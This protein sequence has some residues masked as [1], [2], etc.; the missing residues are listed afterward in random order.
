MRERSNYKDAEMYLAG[1]DDTTTAAAHYLALQHLARVLSAGL[2]A[3]IAARLG[4]AR[5][6][7][8]EAR[9]PA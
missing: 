5:M 7:Q 8:L 3:M 4:P 2:C 1:F 9:L 6:A